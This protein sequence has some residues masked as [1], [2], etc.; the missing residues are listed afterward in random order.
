MA[1]LNDIVEFLDNY[2]AISD[3]KDSSWNGLQ[4]E[5]KPEV[6]KIVFAV[7][8]GIDTFNKAIAAGAD[9]V[10]V[11]HGHFWSS[12]NP[13]I[14]GWNKE[15]IDLLLKSGLSLY[16]AH[17]PLDRHREV[18][19]N[20]ELLKLMGATIREEFFMKDGKNIAWIGEWKEPVSLK[21]VEERINSGLGIKCR[22]LAFGKDKLKSVA[23]C[24]GGGG[25]PCFFEA[26]EKKVDLY[27]TGDAIEI[28][29]HAKDGR[30]NTIFAGHHA[31]ETVGV[32]ALLK[33][34]EKRF[35]LQTEFIDIPTGL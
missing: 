10:V 8:A 18:G 24:S 19:N 4:V 33:V 13:S 20:A 28:M 5:G 25:Y 14:K 27:L 22:V 35:K 16:A 34:V 32:K 6:K 12:A 11:H 1:K 17:L 26:M 31:T 15:R 7:D 2:L 9:M 23:V 29:L 3:I 30:F 21:V